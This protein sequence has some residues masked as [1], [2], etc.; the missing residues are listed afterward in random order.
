MHR[1]LFGIVK[2]GWDRESRKEVVIKI[3]RH[4]LLSS[5]KSVSGLRVMENVV[6]ECEVMR[7][8]QRDLPSESGT[9]I[10]SPA[11]KKCKMSLDIPDKEDM[12]DD[13]A[14]LN[15]SQ[16]ICNLVD[17]LS[18]DQFHYII[19][20]CAQGGDLYAVLSSMPNNRVNEQQARHY[21]KQMVSGVAFM[22]SRGVAHLDLSIENITLTHDDMVKII[23]FGVGTVHPHNPY[24]HSTQSQPVSLA[25]VTDSNLVFPC[26]GITN[27]HEKVGKTGYM[28]SSSSS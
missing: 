8:L 16:Y 15:G 25:H 20:E 4:T 11:H 23:D 6:R 19:T 14:V 27:T 18:D 10:F 24:F 9:P 17:E 1:S 22:H 7:F 13:A 5:S 28:G 3:S 12:Y 2:F 21:F 26:N